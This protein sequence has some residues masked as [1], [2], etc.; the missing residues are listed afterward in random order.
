MIV[1][2]YTTDPSTSATASTSS[3][4]STSNSAMGQSEFLTLL[5]A[6]MQNQDPTNPMDNQQLTA[7]MAQFSS[8]EQLMNINTGLESLLAAT[9]SSTSAQAISLIGKEVTVQGHNVYVQG[10]A[11]PNLAMGLASDA[12]TVTVTI[13]DQNG[14]VVQTLTQSNMSAGV[15]S[16]AWDGKDMYGSPV[17]D[18]L[19]SYS[20]EATDSS[21]NAVDVTTYATGEVSTISFEN[22]VAY[23]HIGDMKY[24]LSEIVEV[25]AGSTTA[26]AS[27]ADT[28]SQ[29]STVN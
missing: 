17:A 10:G 11:A 12:A 1:S 19:Y 18:G 21:G 20:V 26:S 29:T 14:N 5:V 3:S 16:I 23:V 22:G 7:Q 28:Q 25:N 13:E 8:L 4:A 24:M 6:Q 15:Q 27:S 2:S 9:N